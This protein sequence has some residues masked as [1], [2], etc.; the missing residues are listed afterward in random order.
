SP[1]ILLPRLEKPSTLLASHIEACCH[2]CTPAHRPSLLVSRSVRDG[3]HLADELVARRLPDHELGNIGARNSESPSRD[4]ID[5]DAI[6]TF[7][8]SVGQQDGPHRGPL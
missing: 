2:A 7:R 4:A 5:G 1:S 8:R 3:G 6:A